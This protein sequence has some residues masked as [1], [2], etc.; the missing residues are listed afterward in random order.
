MICL[1]F[2]TTTIAAEADDALV[3]QP[4]IVYLGTNDFPLE[5]ADA[6]TRAGMTLAAYNLDA[7]RNLEHRLM[8]GLP[9]SLK[10]LDRIGAI[11]NIVEQRINALPEQAIMNIFQPVMLVQR[12]DIRKVPA[13]VFGNG[14]AVVYGITDAD[15]ILEYWR[16]WR[17]TQGAETR[18]AGE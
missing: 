10:T 14:E 8:E 18:S 15:L 1:F 13:A 17:S 12:W 5:N 11:Q 16:E 4:M 6:A 2:A 3:K 7:H 9:T